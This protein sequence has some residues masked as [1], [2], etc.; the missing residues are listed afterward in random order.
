MKN[1]PK[2]FTIIIAVAIVVIAIAMG[3]VLSNVEN[4]SSSVEVTDEQAKMIA[5]QDA[6]AVEEEVTFIRCVLDNV[7]NRSVYDIE[8]YTD[9]REFEYLIDSGTGSIYS[10]EE[11]LLTAGSADGQPPADT[12]GDDDATSYIGTEK[13]KAIALEDAG[14]TEAAFDK[15]KIGHENGRSVYEVEFKANGKEYEYDIDASTGTILEREVENDD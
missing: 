1:N 2:L 8:F 7:D 10:N 12:G 9:D 5:L 11:T 4:S 15:A 3:L 13:A 6:E 14:L